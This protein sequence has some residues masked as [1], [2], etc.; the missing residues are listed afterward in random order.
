MFSL[1]NVNILENVEYEDPSTMLS[2]NSM[3]IAFNMI[4]EFVI[5]DIRKKVFLH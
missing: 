2:Y 1:Y 5:I 3:R 4:P